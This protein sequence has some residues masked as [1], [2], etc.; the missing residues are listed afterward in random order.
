M[1]RGAAA[2]NRVFEGYVVPIQFSTAQFALHVEANDIAPDASPILL[3]DDGEIVAA[4]TLAI[5]GDCGWIGGF[6]VAPPFR[7]R[8]HATRLLADLLQIARERGL[9]TVALE[10]LEQNEAAIRT[11]E[12]GGFGCLRSLFSFRVE[13]AN[14]SMRPMAAYADANRFINVVR[15]PRSCWQRAA[16]SLA[17]MPSLHAIESG[18]AFA[19]F[20]HNGIEAQILSLR[21][22]SERDLSLL[23]AG[24]AE[25]AGVSRVTLFNEPDGSSILD[26]ARTL[27]WTPTFTQHEMQID[28]QS[29]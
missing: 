6:G 11:Y 3:D 29:P 13:Q 4:G 7:G 15:A 14:P 18:A 21:A 25:N 2:L 17:R 9:A 22:A 10:V 1:E 16:E 26:F 5:R 19:V 8:G 20:R 23:A 28:L 24:I 12:R 27:N